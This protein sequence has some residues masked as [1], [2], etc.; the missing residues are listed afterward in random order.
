[1]E[2]SNC[3]EN[4]RRI[5]DLEKELKKCQKEIELL[6]NEK[7]FREKFTE[8]PEKKASDSNQ[9]LANVKKMS[10]SAITKMNSVLGELTGKLKARSKN[11]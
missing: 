3:I 9:Q 11:N 7:K 2:S 10:V 8:E 6:K 4:Q 5:I 1:M